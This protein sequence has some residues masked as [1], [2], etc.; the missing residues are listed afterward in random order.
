MIREFRPFADVDT[1][2]MTA[3]VDSMPE[4]LDLLNKGSIPNDA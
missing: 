2:A 1:R 4:V 3:Y